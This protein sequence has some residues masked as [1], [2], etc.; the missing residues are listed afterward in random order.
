ML[1]LL[2]I[3]ERRATCTLDPFIILPV[4]GRD[5]A[6]TLDG[7][8]KGRDGAILTC[9]DSSL[10]SAACGVEVIVDVMYACMH[11]SIYPCSDVYWASPEGLSISEKCRKKCVAF[12]ARN[13]VALALANYLRLR[14]Q[15]KRILTLHISFAALIDR[16]CILTCGPLPLHFS[17]PTYDV[18]AAYKSQLEVK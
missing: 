14:D 15:W 3:N 13:H 6:T 18:S 2:C 5:L 10:D 17:T 16:S 12:A 7:P 9:H 1:K 11:A 4:V 8:A